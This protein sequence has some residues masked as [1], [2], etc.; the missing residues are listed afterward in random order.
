[1]FLPRSYTNTI[2]QNHGPKPKGLA[3]NGRGRGGAT[4][5][6]G[7]SSEVLPLRKEGR[8][9]SHAEEGAQQVLG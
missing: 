9:G 2:L 8:G 1:M 7:E 4:K 5:R 3:T 6:E